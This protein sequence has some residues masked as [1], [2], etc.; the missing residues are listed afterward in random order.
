MSEKSLT[1]RQAITQLWERGVLSY[2]LKGK[3][4]DIKEILEKDLNN[5]A[6]ILCSRRFGKSF[7]MCISAIEVCIKKPHAIVKYACPKQKMVKTIVQPIMR[8]ILSD[9]PNHL[10]PEWKEADKKYIF[11]NGSEIQIAG[12]DNGNAENLRGGKADLC[13]IDEAGFCDDLDY[14]IN[15]ILAP[16]TDTTGGKLYLASTPNYKDPQHEFT[17]TFIKPLEAEG[18]LIKFTIYDSP[19]V[20]EKKIKEIKSRYPDGENNPKF[21]CEYLCEIIEEAEDTVIPEFHQYKDKIIKEV[22][23]PA[24]YDYYIACD[25]GFRDL[26]AV[27]LA[28]YD[29]VNDVIVVEDEIVLNGA[30]FTTDKMA[31]AIKEAE[32]RN[33]SNPLTGEVQEPMLRVMDNNNLILLND[34]QTLHGISFIA[35][36]KDDKNAA[37]NNFRMLIQ[38]K[39]LLINPRCKNFIYHLSMARWNNKRDDFLRIKDT[40]SGELKGGHVDLLDACIY[41]TRNVIRGKNPFPANYFDIKGA[42]IFDP[43]SKKEHGKAKE[44]KKMLNIRR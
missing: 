11:P 38:Q 19:M 14:V 30:E 20:D 22:E 41:L 29:F 43:G 4:N 2:K 37:I 42:N 39:K 7:S 18:R 6:V 25:V 33:F 24:F 23:R 15:S 5:I 16:T 28:Y 26:T 34:L 10:K 1:K 9:C 44:L 21:R 13:I 3:Q 40:P 32:A 12:T 31:M 27:L 35:T 36:R 8:E 17:T